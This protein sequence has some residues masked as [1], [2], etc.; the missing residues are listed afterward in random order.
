MAWGLIRKKQVFKIQDSKIIYSFDM[1]ICNGIIV[2]STKQTMFMKDN[3][4]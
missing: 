2:V 1:G 4:T 3:I